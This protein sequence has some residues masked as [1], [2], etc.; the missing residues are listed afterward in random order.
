MLKLIFALASL[1][2]IVQT[3][4]HNCEYELLNSCK[5]LY[6]ILVQYL[7]GDIVKGEFYVLA[8]LGTRL[9]ECD[10]IFLHATTIFT[11]F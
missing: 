5:Y 2:V 11:T 9:H 6:D 3:F 7:L 1:Q 4:N 10:V 8:S